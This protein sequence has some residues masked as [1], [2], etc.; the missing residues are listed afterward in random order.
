[1]LKKEWSQQ[2]YLHY[3]KVYIQKGIQTLLIDT[4]NTPIDGIE[5]ILYNPFEL[6]NYPKGTIFVFY[7]DT[8][9]S[10]GERLEEYQKK[11]PD[12]RCIS[13]FGGRGYWR[14]TLT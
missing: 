12:K 9:K 8:G 6:K 4:I 13:L 2:E 5:T 7:C 14:K 3:K 11:F 1:M 10:T